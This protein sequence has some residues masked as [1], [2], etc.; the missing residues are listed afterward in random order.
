MDN[1][2]REYLPI[3]IFL[4]IEVV[5]QPY[6]DCPRR[7]AAAVGLA[8]LPGLAR[9]LAIYLSNADILPP[10]ALARTA[11]VRIRV[12]SLTGKGSGYPKP[13]TPEEV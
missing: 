11:V 4:G 3:L 12:T 8:I 7:H 6:L 2:L 9:L 13:R 5:A 1:L 10:E